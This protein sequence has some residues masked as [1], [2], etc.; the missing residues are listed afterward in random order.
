MIFLLLL[1]ICWEI[2]MQSKIDLKWD[3]EMQRIDPDLK[4]GI[5]NKY[6]QLAKSRII[7]G[8]ETSNI[9]YPWMVEIVHITRNVLPNGKFVGTRCGG[10]IVS[11][12]S[13]LTAGHCVCIPHSDKKR[14][15]TCLEDSNGP[16]NQNRPENY[17][18]YTF[19]S[20]RA[21]KRYTKLKFNKDIKAF[22]HNYDSTWWTNSPKKEKKKRLSNWKNGDAAVI[23]NENG[24]NLKSNQAIPICLPSPDI[25]ENDL[26]VTLIGRGEMYEECP[27]TAKSIPSSCMTNGERIHKA[28]PNNAEFKFMPCK[29]YR[30]ENHGGNCF[31]IANARTSK[32]DKVESGYKKG[33]ISTD[34]K[35]TF[36]GNPGDI[37]HQM[38]IVIPQDD[39][40]EEL[41]DELM[42]QLKY[43][44]KGD[45]ELSIDDVKF[46]SR[47]V[48]FEIDHPKEDIDSIYLS[49]EK[50]PISNRHTYC[51][52]IKTV[53]E[54][55]VCETELTR[56]LSLILK[57]QVVINFGFCGPSCQN[58]NMH[59]LYVN[60]YSQFKAFNRHQWKME[61]IYHENYDADDGFSKYQFNKLD[62]LSYD[63]FSFLLMY[64]S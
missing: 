11:D 37:S 48:V 59:E 10:T 1:L 63:Y 56:P 8:I 2:A 31:S 53:A 62:V 47:I 57:K 45:L 19:G 35:I 41:S 29:N 51:Y 18:H 55:G 26:E 42:K 52:N 54:F 38:E 5:E 20:M 28:V 32:G 39:K 3:E 58:P 34:L 30:R 46:P 22:L 64:H 23:M 60:H 33:L 12:K 40:C 61:A 4:C 6:K 50:L 7:N 25:F 13:I 27:P 17:V 16:Q 36:S 14:D 43:S 15:P 21:V 24:L 44:E 9:K 49:W